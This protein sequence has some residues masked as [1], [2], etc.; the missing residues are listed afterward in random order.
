M[1]ID[2]PKDRDYNEGMNGEKEAKRDETGQYYAQT[3]IFSVQ[4]AL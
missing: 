2:F 3:G 4:S 1:Y